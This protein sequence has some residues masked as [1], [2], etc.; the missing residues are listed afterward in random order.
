MGDGR[1]AFSGAIDQYSFALAGR[2]IL[3]AAADTLLPSIIQPLDDTDFPAAWTYMGPTENAEVTLNLSLTVE[4]I[5]TGVVP[6]S[7]RKIITEQSGTIEAVLHRYEPTLM[8]KAQGVSAVSTPSTSL[9]R[10]I[11]DLYLG[12]TLGDIISVLIFEDFGE[13]LVID[14]GTKDYSQV[15]FYTPRAQKNGDVNLAQ[16]ISR[17]PAINFNYGLLGYTNV[18]APGRTILIQQRWLEAA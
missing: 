15:W 16:K 13:D 1:I 11:V 14:D 3:V 18:A 9:N 12:G 8:A 7:R 17:A 6:T 4:D 5:T 10:A 2:G